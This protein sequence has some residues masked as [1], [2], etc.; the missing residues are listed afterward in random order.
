MLLFISRY[1]LH[2]YLAYHLLIYVMTYLDQIIRL[3]DSFVEI[4][5]DVQLLGMTV[6]M[7]GLL[8]V[9]GGTVFL[10]IIPEDSHFL[11]EVCHKIKVVD[12]PQS[13]LAVVIIQAL[14]GYPCLLGCIM[15]ADPGSM[16]IV[17]LDMKISPHLDQL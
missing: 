8:T 1:S 6:I 2:M 5:Q 16:G 15:K 9:S 17:P 13:E 10:D 3:R 12:L 11:V 4:F 14:L 7:P